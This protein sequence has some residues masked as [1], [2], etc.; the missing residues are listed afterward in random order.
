MRKILLNF[1]L[2]VA[3]LNVWA[4]QDAQYS[5]YMF[6]SLV[7]N[8]AYAGYKET[9]NLSLLYRNQ[10]VDVP[11]APKTQSLVL[12]AAVA[13]DKIGLGL[14]V[15]NDKSG[16][17][18][19]FSAFA[20]IA[21]R[22]PLAGES[23][24]SF[25]LGVGFTQLGVNGSAA[26]IDDISDTEFLSG[27]STGLAPDIRFG[28]HYSTE[29]LYIGLSAINLMEKAVDFST[30]SQTLQVKQSQNYFL[31][32]GY[33]V[34]VSDFLKFKPS[35]MVREDVKG[36]TNLDI[37]NFF[38]LGERIWLGASYR[39]SLKLWDKPAVIGMPRSN[40]AVVGLV[41]FFAGK[42]WRIGYA[43][44]YSL[45]NIRGYDNG[46]HEISLGLIINGGKRD[47]TILS[48]RYF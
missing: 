31:T 1:I 23:R 7:I 41:E 28:I 2:L 39:T 9:V 6:N 11:G 43:Y 12:D 21:Y 27:N 29:K 47:L 24:L 35:I 5:Q 33:L 22:I 36:P 3:S 38:L 46:T 10:W 8:P 20:N 37:N 14:S 15:V 48:P 19:Q 13:D 44:D 18:D 4:Q 32:A 25:G 17:Q 40:N 45:S 34:E 26:I 16:I 30:S 42:S